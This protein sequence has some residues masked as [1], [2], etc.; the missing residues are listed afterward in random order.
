METPDNKCFVRRKKWTRHLVSLPPEQDDNHV[1]ELFVTA[2]WRSKAYLR[3]EHKLLNA[4]LEDVQAM[5]NLQFIFEFRK[6][7]EEED[8]APPTARFPN[9]Q[10]VSMGLVKTPEFDCKIK[11]TG[12]NIL[13]IPGLGKAI[14]KTFLGSLVMNAFT[15]PMLLWD[16]DSWSADSRRREKAL[17]MGT[18]ALRTKRVSER[19]EGGWKTCGE[20]TRGKRRENGRGRTEEV[21]EAPRKERGGE[22]E[23][24]KERRS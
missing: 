4:A 7:D 8:A 23:E 14:N 1:Y 18:E 22:G 15:P 17:A 19:K 11:T 6:L 16:A 2:E 9:L 3:C 13:A 10:R 24:G 12:G 5:M 20:K 21:K